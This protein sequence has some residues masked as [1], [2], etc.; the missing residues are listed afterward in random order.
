MASLEIPKKIPWFIY[1]YKTSFLLT[2]NNVP[3]QVSSSRQINRPEQSIP[4]GGTAI[5]K[6]GNMGPLK[7]AFQIKIGA[8]NDEL[9]VIDQLKFFE[10]LR[11]PVTN[12]FISSF[13]TAPPFT[14]NP[15]IIYWYG[16]GTLMPLFYYVTKCDY[17]V[18]KFN[19]WGYPQVAS[20]D[21]EFVL[22]EESDMYRAEVLAS[23]VLTVTGSLTSLIDT[24]TPN[25][26]KNP[27]YVPSKIGK[28][29]KRF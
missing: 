20:V 18:T 11:T 7:I 24:F 15:E 27:Y 22:N 2:S 9:G 10:Q 5:A 1:I 6:Y 13:G 3:D 29:I 8:F 28:L 12:S 14:P 19:R 26:Y 16:T 17:T 25:K 23:K 21:C 4:G